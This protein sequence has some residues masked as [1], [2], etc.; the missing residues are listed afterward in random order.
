MATP[1]SRYAVSPTSR[2][3]EVRYL[4]LSAT[5]RAVLGIVEWLAF[6]TSMDVFRPSTLSPKNLR[7]YFTN[8]DNRPSEDQ[9]TAALDELYSSD[10][11]DVPAY[12]HKCEGG[13]WLSEIGGVGKHFKFGGPAPKDKEHIWGPIREHKAARM[14][15]KSKGGKTKGRSEEED[16]RWAGEEGE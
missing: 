13:V 4:E 5:A 12:F 7:R 16:E 10:E 6:S 1:G 3:D 9:I 2:L 15:R 11:G 8:E 14:A